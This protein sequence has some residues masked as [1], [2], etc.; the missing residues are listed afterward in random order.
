M[1]TCKDLRRYGVRILLGEDRPIT[2]WT[3]SDVRSLTAFMTS[4]LPEGTEG[5]SEHIRMVDLASKVTQWT[6]DETSL[7]RLV[8][9]LR[10]STNLYAL[11]LN[12]A[13]FRFPSV[14]QSLCA[15]PS[16]FGSLRRIR[17]ES[18]SRLSIPAVNAGGAAV[19]AQAASPYF[20]EKLD[21]IPL[22]VIIVS[23]FQ[24]RISRTELILQ[25]SRFKDTL[26]ELH[27]EDTQLMQGF[28]QG[29][30]PTAVVFPR[31]RVLSMTHTTHYALPRHAD[32]LITV[33]PNIHTL[34]FPISRVTRGSTRTPAAFQVH[35]NAPFGWQAIPFEGENALPPA[36][37]THATIRAVNE[38]GQR[39]ARWNAL[40]YYQ[41]SL[42][43][44]YL[45]AIRSQV[46]KLK[47]TDFSLLS[48]NIEWMQSVVRELAPTKLCLEVTVQENADVE[49][50][51]LMPR[52]LTRALRYLEIRLL[53]WNEGERLQV[54]APTTRVERERL[55]P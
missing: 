5:R 44:L 53:N 41:G 31:L 20:L 46:D 45:L 27:I 8:N 30:L 12:H 21:G 15:S 50:L 48:S 52:D 34:A 9:L 29:A 49:L 40:T 18:P 43:H 14:A 38:G 55:S 2:F 11:S 35:P 25:V 3:L 28:V 22:E 1:S 10:Q 19:A 16:P 13:F 54:R 42:E 7:N 32:T 39:H 4:N 36:A 24:S 37:H 23:S 47:I 6:H 51:N 26:Q 33:F 17:L